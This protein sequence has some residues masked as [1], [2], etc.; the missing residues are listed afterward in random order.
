M[1][2]LTAEYLSSS[3]GTVVPHA[4]FF[5]LGGGVSC[6]RV[7]KRTGTCGDFFFLFFFSLWES[8]MGIM[9]LSLRSLMTRIRMELM[10]TYPS[11]QKTLRQ[12]H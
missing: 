11:H 6:P 9:A 10:L 3:S 7:L 2:E 4:D 12:S 8:E 5:F 1:L